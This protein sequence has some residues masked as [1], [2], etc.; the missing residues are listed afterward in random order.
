MRSQAPPTGGHA[1]HSLSAG[2][3]RENWRRGRESNPRTRLC[4]PLHNHFATPPSG[5]RDVRPGHK[6]KRKVCSDFPFLHD[7]CSKIWSGRR[8]SN[9]RP[10]PWQGCALPTELLPHLQS[11]SIAKPEGFVSTAR[12]GLC[13]RHAGFVSTARRVCVNRTQGWGR[14]KLVCRTLGAEINVG[15][16]IRMSRHL[17][18]PPPQFA[19]HPAGFVSAAHGFGVNRASGARPP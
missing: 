6:R 11:A 5:S 10:Q 15:Q 1:A 12:R 13:Q 8:V 17:T 19:S 16:A 3:A 14:F 7:L 2:G 18:A 9:S 4:R